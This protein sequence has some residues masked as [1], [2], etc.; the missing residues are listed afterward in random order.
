MTGQARRPGQMSHDQT[1]AE[2]IAAEKRASGSSFSMQDRDVFA[3][4]RAA[5]FAR[6]GQ[7]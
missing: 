3:E 6:G 7:Q 4:R 5:V 1:S 2:A